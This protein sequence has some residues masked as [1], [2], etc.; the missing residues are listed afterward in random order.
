M[1]VGPVAPGFGLREAMLIVFQM[2]SRRLARMHCAGGGSR[3]WVEVPRFQ[4]WERC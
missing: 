1:C 3:V 4:L 2:V